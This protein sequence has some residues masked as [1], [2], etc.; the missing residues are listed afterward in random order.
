ML[1]AEP[2]MNPMTAGMEINSK[3]NPKRNKPIPRAI[4]PQI[5]DKMWQFQEQ[6]TCHQ[7]YLEHEQ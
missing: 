4:P 7:T 3:M 2:V 5:N 1:N 6:H